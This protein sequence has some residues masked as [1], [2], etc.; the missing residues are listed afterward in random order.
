M[1][2]SILT[3]YVRIT[4]YSDDNTLIKFSQKLQAA[5]YFIVLPDLSHDNM[6]LL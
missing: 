1:I 5:S 4:L 2:S 3:D 6:S